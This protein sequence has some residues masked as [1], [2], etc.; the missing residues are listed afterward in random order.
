MIKMQ[1]ALPAMQH[2]LKALIK[3][4]ESAATKNAARAPDNVATRA[5]TLNDSLEEIGSMFSEKMESK[6]KALNRRQMQSNLMRNKH[7]VTKVE[8][9]NQ[10]FQLM[11]SNE[12]Q[13]LDKLLDRLRQALART[14]APDSE[15]LLEEMGGD[16]ARCD[17][18][19]RMVQ[20]HATEKGEMALADAASQHLNTLQQQH[21]D[22]IRAGSNTASAIAEFTNDPQEKQ[23]LRNLYYDS[24]VHHQSA[25]AM[26]DMLLDQVNA[27]HFVPTLRTLQRA[28][29]DDIA[30]LAPSISAGAL[31]RIQHGLHEAGQLSHTL[32]ASSTLLKRM[33]NKL[34]EVALS[35]VELTRRLL[36]FSHNGVYNR[37]FQHLGEEVVGQQSQHLSL[38]FSCLF[39][40]VHQ[41]PH[42][43]WK[44]S[45]SRKTALELLRG[46]ITELAKAEQQQLARRSA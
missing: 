12:E 23:S 37:D 6:N 9:L 40:L 21:G 8:H 38:F 27:Q 33:H 43:L 26:L 34:P 31:R 32:A 39:P 16:P 19:L 4:G 41:L 17:L 29:A 44:E 15:A 14:P 10:L 46:I 35:A 11:E 42:S 18:L 28:L 24:I 2:T 36:Q 30:A 1:P 25:I 3:A 22:T 45:D 20:Q 7:Q 13:D 5:E